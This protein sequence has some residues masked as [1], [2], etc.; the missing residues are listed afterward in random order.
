MRIHCKQ[1]FRAD[2]HCCGLRGSDPGHFWADESASARSVRGYASVD[3]KR[4]I[5]LSRMQPH[6]VSHRKYLH[7]ATERR[8]RDGSVRYACIAVGKRIRRAVNQ[9]KEHM[10]KKPTIKKRQKSIRI[11]DCKTFTGYKPCF[12]GINM[13]CRMCGSESGGT[14]DPHHQSR[15]DGGGV[16]N[17]GN[18]AGHQAEIP[19]KPYLLDNLEKRP[20]PSRK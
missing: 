11:P 20:P 5:G 18:A 12:P 1:R 14:K 13:L 3:Q 9:P 10:K 6:C 17:N 15:C 7:D 16:A 19:A 4:R 8:P 2:A